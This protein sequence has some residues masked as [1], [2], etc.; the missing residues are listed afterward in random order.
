M[1]HHCICLFATNNIEVEGQIIS[2]NSSKIIDIVNK[3]P[4]AENAQKW[5]RGSERDQKQLYQWSSR[6]ALS[7]KKL[8]A[9]KIRCSLFSTPLLLIG[10]AY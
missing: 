9:V 1:R 5:M 6:N 7:K 4:T 2:C 3:V 10:K 8:N